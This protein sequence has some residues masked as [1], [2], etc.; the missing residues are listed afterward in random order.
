MAWTEEPEVALVERSQLGLVQPL[1]QRHHGRVHKA[2]IGVG[3]AVTQ[4]T[5]LA[6]VLRLQVCDDVGSVPLSMTAH[7]CAQSRTL[8][9]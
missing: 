3:V 9:G 5:D 1:D 4:L 7:A 8:R 2:D 6:I